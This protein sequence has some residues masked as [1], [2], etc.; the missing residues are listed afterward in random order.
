MMMLYGQELDALGYLRFQVKRALQKAC[1]NVREGTADQ[2]LLYDAVFSNQTHF[3]LDEACLLA[4]HFSWGPNNLSV[5]G[6]SATDAQV[7][8][9]VDAILS[10]LITRQK[11][12]TVVI[13]LG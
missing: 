2:K 6:I 9:C 10:E 12:R 11:A 13:G 7:Q 5:L 4:W 1:F 3:G 8:I